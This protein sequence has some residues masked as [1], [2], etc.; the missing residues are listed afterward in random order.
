MTALYLHNAEE[1]GDLVEWLA[2]HDGEAGYPRGL[3]ES[4]VWLAAQTIGDYPA[5][6]PLPPEHLE[7]MTA[8]ID[9]W[10][11]VLGS[12]D[13]DLKSRIEEPTKKPGCS[14]QFDDVP[15]CCPAFRN[16]YECDNCGT[17]WQDEW[18]CGCDDQCPSCGRDIEASESVQIAACACDYLGKA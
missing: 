4:A 15:T 7:P 14:H 3:L 16:S 12:H 6:V 8:I 17:T 10:A 2:S 1:H 18:S 13:E 11:E 5:R 9:D